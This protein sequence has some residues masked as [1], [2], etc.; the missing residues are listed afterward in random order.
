MNKKRYIKLIKLIDIERSREWER[1]MGFLMINISRWIQ[2]LN[3]WRAYFDFASYCAEKK[4]KENFFFLRKGKEKLIMCGGTENVCVRAH[5]VE[6]VAFKISSNWPFVP[7][8]FPAVWA[9][10]GYGWCTFLV[11][12]FILLLIPKITYSS[13][14]C[15]NKTYRWYIFLYVKWIIGLILLTTL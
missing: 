4:R 1:C 8:L 12:S 13:L 3:I 11:N 10:R 15:Q 7:S 5:W 9:A 6:T 2:K 14:I